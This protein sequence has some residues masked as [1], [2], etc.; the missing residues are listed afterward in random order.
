MED[1][2]QSIRDRYIIHLS[3]GQMSLRST[4]QGYQYEGVDS[5]QRITYTEY[6]HHEKPHGYPL[7]HQWSSRC[8]SGGVVFGPMVSLAIRSEAI[9]FHCTFSQSLTIQILAVYVGYS[10]FRFVICSRMY[11][12]GSYQLQQKRRS[13][14]RFMRLSL[15]SL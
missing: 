11:L 7:T 5:C 13:P 15:K 2:D 8:C 1:N 12:D 4:V 6:D 9:E 14:M 3:Y 10:K